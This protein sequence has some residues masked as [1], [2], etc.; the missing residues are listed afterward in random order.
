MPPPTL[1]VEYRPS[2]LRQ[3]GVLLV[4]VAVTALGVVLLASGEL[5][6]TVV[7]VA[8]IA[9]FGVLGVP[10]LGWHSTR[11]PVMIRLT[12]DGVEL[13]QRPV[14]P[15]SEIE[16]VEA[17]TVAGAR[18]VV[19]WLHDGAVDRLTAS[20]AA[21]AKAMRNDRRVLGR[22]AVATAPGV[23]GGPHRLAEEI[24]EHLQRVRGE[25]PRPG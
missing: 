12:R 10:V 16:G 20:G 13:H 2:R 6:M 25:Q 17:R 24:R 3:A 8:M 1:P 23:E 9:L 22:D 18:M 15:W 5:V 19:L 7:G 4:A 14:V 11:R 21:G